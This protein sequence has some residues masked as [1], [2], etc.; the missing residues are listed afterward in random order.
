MAGRPA[1]AAELYATSLGGVYVL[2]LQIGESS[3]GLRVVSGLLSA[4]PPPATA[5]DRAGLLEDQGFYAYILGNLI[6]SRQAYEESAALFRSI[7]NLSKLANVLRLW[8]DLERTVGHLTRSRELAEESLNIVNSLN[9]DYSQIFAHSCLA[10]TLVCLG[11]TQLAR[12]H[13]QKATELERHELFSGRGFSEAELKYF[14]GD[15]AGARRQTLNNR[16]MSEE[17]RVERDMALCDSLLGLLTLHDSGDLATAGRH[18][19]SAR[20]YATRSGHLE[21]QLRCHILAGRI[22]AAQEAL[23]AAKAEFQAGIDLADSCEFKRLG[24]DLRL[25]FAA[26]GI[27]MGELNEVIAIASS[28]LNWSECVDHQYEWGAADALHLL[29]VANAR[30][31]QIEDARTYLASAV[32]RRIGL[33]HRGVAETKSMLQGL[34]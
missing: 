2:S 31:G 12:D 23:T 7:G 13:F 22:E 5:F 24:A 21:V 30:L 15:V 9:Q 34:A 29:G 27:R 25:E 4:G 32:T 20:A 10:S 28:V 8:A 18:L 19:D 33:G 14:T 3:R 6:L 1:D 16:V 11:E 17:R 26:V